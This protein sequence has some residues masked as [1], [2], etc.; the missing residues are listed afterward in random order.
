MGLERIFLANPNAVLVH[1]F[2]MHGPGFRE[3]K[4]ARAN[5]GQR[6]FS[7]FKHGD[8]VLDAKLDDISRHCIG[9]SA[10]AVGTEQTPAPL[11]A[12]FTVAQDVLYREEKQEGTAYVCIYGKEDIVTPEIVDKVVR[13]CSVGNHSS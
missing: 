7:L 5:K 2:R 8:P 6:T 11:R 1:Y 3:W 9:E 13:A 10:A 12:A 4:K